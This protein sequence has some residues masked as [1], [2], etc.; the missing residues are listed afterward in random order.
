MRPRNLSFPL[1]LLCLS[2]AALL[3]E[4]TKREDDP[5]RE[6]FFPPRSKLIAHGT[7]SSL[8]FLFFLPIGILIARY[9]SLNPSYWL[10][11][12]LVIQTFAAL[13]IISGFAI[14][15][16]YNHDAYDGYDY[17]NRIGI[18]LFVLYLV[19][20]SLGFF[21][22][23]IKLPSLNPFLSSSSKLASTPQSQPPHPLATH[24]PQ[25][26]FHVIIGLTILCLSI[27]QVRTGYRDMYPLWTGL[28][29]P[30]T[31]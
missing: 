31:G 8:G 11:V 16:N 3:A 13:L 1:F 18:A 22:H 27:Y 4:I 5:F 26:I 15:V 29:T 12:H 25:N 6:V 28:D 14:G 23:Y 30:G 19:Q 2:Q 7:L 21:I 9:R 24:P 10:R 17:R 20:F